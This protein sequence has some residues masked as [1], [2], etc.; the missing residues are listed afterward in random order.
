MRLTFEKLQKLLSNSA[1]INDVVHFDLLDGMLN[2]R[3][4][5]N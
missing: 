5:L 1:Q 3:R 4:D 2:T